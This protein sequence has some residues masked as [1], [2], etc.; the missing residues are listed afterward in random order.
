MANFLF[1]HPTSV[2]IYPRIV[3]LD[4]SDR[5]GT[6]VA[7]VIVTMSRRSGFSGRL[8][9][10]GNRKVMTMLTMAGNEVV[11]ARD[12]T[13]ADDTT[14]VTYTVTATQNGVS[15]TSAPATLMI[16]S[17][18]VPTAVMLSPDSVTLHDTAVAGAVVSSAAVT[19]SDGSTFAGTYEV[20]GPA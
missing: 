5:R 6:F 18:V 17:E 16:T 11:L 8:T 10:R 20:T 2:T 7:Q 4:S 14:G 12:L 13:S 1:N 9:I 3:H 15:V 19:M